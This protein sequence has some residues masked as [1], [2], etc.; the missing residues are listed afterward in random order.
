MSAMTPA[1]WM[2]WSRAAL[3]GDGEAGPVGVDAGLGVGGVGHGGAQELVGDQQGVDLLV[4]AG[5]GAGA[6]DPAA[7]DAGLQFQ[8]GGLDLP[9]LVVERIS[10]AAG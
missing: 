9:S 2:T 10:S 8:V 3:Q 4:D 5:R 6:Q 7:Q 1:A